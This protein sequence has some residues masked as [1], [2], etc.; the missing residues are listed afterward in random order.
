MFGSI[1]EKKM[2]LNIFILIIQVSFDN[3]PVT[4][5]PSVLWVILAMWFFSCVQFK[6]V[7]VYQKNMIC[8]IFTIIKEM[9][10]FYEYLIM[11]CWNLHV[12]IRKT[13]H[14]ANSTEE[15]IWKKQTSKENW[16]RG[17]LNWTFLPCLLYSFKSRE[18]F[19][20]VLRLA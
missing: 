11:V 2:F 16:R 4:H 6:N 1:I 12:G 15:R 5:F 9:I 17:K 3:L 18:F 20:F 14:G 13:T 8:L 7:L 19:F 10:S